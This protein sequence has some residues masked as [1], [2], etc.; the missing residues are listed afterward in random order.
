MIFLYKY[1]C[2]CFDLDDTLLD[3]EESQRKAILKTFEHFEL[4]QT[5]QNVDLYDAC[6]K[7]CWAE[8]EQQKITKDR[9]RTLRFERF[10][11]RI[12]QQ[13]DP[14]DMHNFYYNLL[15]TGD[16]I[17]PGAIEMLTEVSEFA[18]IAITTNGFVTVQNGRLKSSGV[19]DFVDEVITSEQLGALKPD[20]EFFKKALNLLGVTNKKRV[21]VIGDRLTADVAGANNF[22]LDS[23]WFNMRG[24]QNE[25]QHIPTYTVGNYD[26][27]LEILRQ[28]E[29]EIVWQPV[30]LE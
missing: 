24:E 19:A 18:T 16:D 30:R 23:C 4:P 9:L 15:A 25:T 27:L 22:G 12:G 5:Q 11:Q 3:F 28:Q 10:L 21:L 1:N 8:L 14:L 26:E 13:R 7:E 20:P 17:I 6:N 29:E 2:L